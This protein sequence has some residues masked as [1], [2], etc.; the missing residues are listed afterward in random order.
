VYPDPAYDDSLADRFRDPSA[1]AFSYNRGREFTVSHPVPAGQEIFLNYGWCTRSDDDS[2]PSWT[3]G[4]P[5]T[6]DFELA[7]KLIS[8]QKPP[9]AS[10]S[11]SRIEPRPF[12]G[13]TASWVQNVLLL[14]SIRNVTLYDSHE[15]LSVPE[16]LDIPEIVQQLLPATRSELE[17]MLERVHDEVAD[18]NED[19][20]VKVDDEKHDDEL[21]RQ[22]ALSSLDRKS[23]DEI[24]ARGMCMDNLLARRSTLPW[25]GQGGF[26]QRTIRAGDLVVPAPLLQ[27]LDRDALVLYDSE[28]NP[29]G[30]QLLLN[31]C[32][33]H[34]ES[35]LLLCPNT[36]AVLINHCS[37]RTR[38][39]G[40]DGPNA[41]YRWATGWDPT[42]D[43]WRA[44]SLDELGH[45]EVRGLAFEV[46]ALR[47]IRPGDEV[48]IDYGVEWEQAWAWHVA[49]WKPASLPREWSSP[50]EWVSAT[51]AN[52]ESGP[53]LHELIS[54][55]L[56]DTVSHPYLFT[57]CQYWVT[58]EDEHPV[59]KTP[60]VWTELSDEDILD[61]YSDPGDRFCEGYRRSYQYHRDQS[62]WPCT[63]LQ[64]NQEED[65]YVVRIHRP[66]WA[67]DTKLPWDDNDLPRL[68]RNYKRSSIH[69]FA[70]PFATDQHLPG[71]FRH[72]IRIRDEI[73]PQQWK[74]LAAKLQQEAANLSHS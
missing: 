17:D 58:E 45:Q 41:Q 23:V 10:E 25:A 56:R 57:A 64:H 29:N 28:G 13:Y 70:L 69:Y 22:I 73:F 8:S 34:A 66:P 5:V 18:R 12:Q 42:S 1:G 3:V 74:N 44:M 43:A 67:G 47:D 30:T 71:V 21:V 14:R 55:G 59:Y 38:E 72:D 37:V 24:R 52:H 26:A 36:N 60:Q 7:A 40:Q 53:V 27:I 20:E 35:T 61:R 4:L 50:A 48:F 54:G 15:K 49:N 16:S 46:V 62:H 65:T 32:F 11:P 2:P 6:S 39:C 9:S 68:L 31:Y 63:I 19:G 33:G 51:D